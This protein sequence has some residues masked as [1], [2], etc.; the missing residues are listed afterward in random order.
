MSVLAARG[1][2]TR[3][4]EKGEEKRKEGEV[5]GDDDLGSQ[6]LFDEM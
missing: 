2:F 4:K 3:L 6:K 5:E 1:T